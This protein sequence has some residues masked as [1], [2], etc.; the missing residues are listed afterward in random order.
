MSQLIR[1]RRAKFR[2]LHE[3]GCFILPNPWDVGSARMLEH[4]GFAALASTSAGFAWSIGR[5]DY[6]LPRDRV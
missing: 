4:L 5:L 1:E 6:G 2:K 3:C